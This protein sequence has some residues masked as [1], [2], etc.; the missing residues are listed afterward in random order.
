V[1]RSGRACRNFDELLLACQ[2][3]WAAGVEALRSG[4]FATFFEHIGRRD[5]ALLARSAASSLDVS[6]GLHDLLGSLPSQALPPPRLLVPVGEIVL[7]DLQVGQDHSFNLS[8]VNAGGRLLYGSVQTDCPWLSLGS[9]GVVASKAFEF[10]SEMTLPVRVCG[11]LL[12]AC[13]RPLEGRLDASSNGGEGAVEVRVMVAA[14]VFAHGVLAGA[15][16]PRELIDKVTAAPLQSADWF[17]NGAVAEWYE[18]NGWS[19]P[20]QG[21]AAAGLDGVRQFFHALGLPEP[22]LTPPPAPP[23]P[24]PA[25]PRG[26]VVQLRGAVGQALGHTLNIKGR[27]RGVRPITAAA[28]SDQPWLGI[29][30]TKVDDTSATVLLV[31]PAVPN[32]P[33]ETL[34]AQVNLTLNGRYQRVI[35]VTLAVTDTATGRPGL[36]S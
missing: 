14:K 28:T 1:F 34:H 35:P 5:L 26:L 32:R 18:T 24:V 25:A 9:P 10:Q 17:D 16:S 20:V 19:Y 30:S 23:V 22:P 7:P 12:R 13:P 31:V 33:G 36:R 2:E 3:N 29:R 27:A 15:A 11:N 8:L 4:L 6:R 21:P